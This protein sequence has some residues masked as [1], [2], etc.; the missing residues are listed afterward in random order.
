MMALSRHAFASGR[1]YAALGLLAAAIAGCATLV[2]TEP[3]L[4]FHSGRF[5]A[6][7]SRGEHREAVSGRFTLTVYAGRTTLDLA[8]PLG[9]TLA[10]VQTDA[11]GATLTAPQ[12]D[13]TLATLYGDNPDALAES[14]LGFSLPVSG[15]ADWIAGR[16]VPG[17]PARLVPEAGPAQR[18]EQDDWL[19]VID[20]R[21]EDTRAPRRL[22]FDRHADPATG[23][24][25]RLRLV[26]DPP[27]TATGAQGSF[28]Q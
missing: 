9:N 5:A 12:A 20:E 18:I 22:S 13:G 7:I 28:R 16:P 15:L 10:R 17:R 11:T 24:S 2:P 25:L 21:F 14:V 4:D 8:S 6:S 3:V 23:T 26:L 19:I 1:G 27:T